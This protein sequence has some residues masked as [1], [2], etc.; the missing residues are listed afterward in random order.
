MIIPSSAVY[1]SNRPVK[2]SF[3]FVVDHG[4]A[5]RRV[6]QIGRERGSTLEIIQGLNVGDVLI[7]NQNIEVTEGVRVDS[8]R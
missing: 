8:R 1:R 5:I 2:D 3:V 7:A 6:V 4:K